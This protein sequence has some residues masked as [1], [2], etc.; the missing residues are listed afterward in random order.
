VDNDGGNG[1]VVLDTA[2]LTIRG[3]SRSS[4]TVDTSP[5]TDKVSEGISVRADDVTLERL[6]VVGPSSASADYGT[7]FGIKT[8]SGDGSTL[9]GIT[10]RD[11]TVRDS[12]NVELQLSDVDDT[13][14]E[15]VTVDGGDSPTGAGIGIEDAKP[16]TEEQSITLRDVTAVDNTYGG[17]AVFNLDSGTVE[18]DAITG[19]T[20]EGDMSFQNSVPALYVEDEDLNTIADGSITDDSG[21]LTH[22]ALIDDDEQSTQ[23]S[24][25]TDDADAD[26]GSYRYY[27]TSR[28]QAVDDL[29]ASERV[30]GPALGSASEVTIEEL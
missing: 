5:S 30:G 18:K 12:G 11:V 7:N 21:A 29:N 1:A 15:N 19:L 9:T 28:S 17:I 23:T 14:V 27:Y 20:L 25:E 24:Q 10:V 22:R 8:R 13:L 26:R 4:V 16:F 6:T 2:G 3:D